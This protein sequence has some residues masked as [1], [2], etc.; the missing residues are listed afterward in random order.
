MGRARVWVPLL[1]ATVVLV[2]VGIWYFLRDEY[3]FQISQ[4]DIVQVDYETFG[5]FGSAAGVVPTPPNLAAWIGGMELNTSGER[6]DTNAVMVVVL[7]DGR[8]L[9]LD[10]GAT[11]AYGTW[12]TGGQDGDSVGVDIPK[13]F[14]SYL[15]GLAAGLRAA[16]RTFTPS[17][18][19]SP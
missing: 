12:V 16:P 17:S 11:T 8:S 6:T 19:P 13:P 9:R 4:G 3:P 10:L 14:R 5:S 2:S 1:I 15:S 7:R 18:S